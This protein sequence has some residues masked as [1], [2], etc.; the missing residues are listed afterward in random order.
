M[1]DARGFSLG[2]QHLVPDAVVAF[3][4]GELSAGAHD[5]AA[6]HLARCPSCAAEA[7]A[8]R[9]ARLAVRSADTPSVSDTLLASLR[10]IPQQV[11]LPGG[12]DELAVTEDGQLVTVQ[13]PDRVTL[14]S[15][16]RALIGSSEP[17]GSAPAVLGY[18]RGTASRRAVQ[19]AGVVVSGLVLGALALVTPPAAPSSS[20]SSPVTDESAAAK[21]SAG[22]VQ[23]A[24]ASAA[25]LAGLAAVSEPGRIGPE[26]HPVGLPAPRS[27]GGPVAAYASRS[28]VTSTFAQHGAAQLVGPP[29]LLAPLLLDTPGAA[30][31]GPQ[32]PDTDR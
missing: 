1:T 8:Q 24:S 6:A 12:P 15:T 31:L 5:R 13:R 29:P 17:L 2:E 22:R 19:G 4:D 30:P 28:A 23:Q 3:V 7:A 21:G 27:A 16:G 9:Q 14:Q 11:D 20:A 26:N 18:R 10:A 25:T 32:P